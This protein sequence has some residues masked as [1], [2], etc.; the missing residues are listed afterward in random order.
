[1]GSMLQIC[2]FIPIIII[3]GRKQVGEAVLYGRIN[4]GGRNKLRLGGSTSVIIIMCVCMR[5]F[6]TQGHAN[7][8]LL[9]LQAR[10]NTKAAFPEMEAELN[11][12]Y[13][14]LG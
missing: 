11:R 14:T 2:I 13:H 12:E 3:S 7:F 10:N 9:T 1:M 4:S 5:P 6:I 8:W